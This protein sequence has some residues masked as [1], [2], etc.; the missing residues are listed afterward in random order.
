MISTVIVSF[1]IVFF[2][3]EQPQTDR[4]THPANATANHFL[5]ANLL[6]TDRMGGSFTSIK[7]GHGPGDYLFSNLPKDALEKSHAAAAFPPLDHKNQA[8]VLTLSQ[9]AAPHKGFR[10]L[11]AS[12]PSRNYEG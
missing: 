7:P 1:G 4:R 11:D 2:W 10:I 3:A 12:A 6:L 5:I 9:P 8:P